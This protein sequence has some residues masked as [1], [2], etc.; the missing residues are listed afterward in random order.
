MLAMNVIELTML[1]V[2][3]RVFSKIY[4]ELSSGSDKIT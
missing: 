1:N 2:K 3:A 4:T